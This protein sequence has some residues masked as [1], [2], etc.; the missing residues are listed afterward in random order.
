M[1]KIQADSEY[2]FS[3]QQLID[4]D[5]WFCDQNYGAAPGSNK[6]FVITTGDTPLL[7]RVFISTTDEPVRT[8]VHE[9]YEFHGGTPNTAIN[10]SR[11]SSKTTPVIFTRDTLVDDWGTKIHVGCTTVGESPDPFIEMILKANTNYIFETKN[12]GAGPTTI[13]TRACWCE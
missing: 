11:R 5:C 10:L 6:N 8:N 4:G 1:G 9:D 13:Y 12:K 7:V 2:A 3:V